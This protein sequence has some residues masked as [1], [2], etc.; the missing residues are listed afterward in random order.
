MQEKELYMRPVCEAVALQAEGIVC[1]SVPT[2]GSNNE[3]VK[4]GGDYDD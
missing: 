2:R 3:G 1:V 4:W